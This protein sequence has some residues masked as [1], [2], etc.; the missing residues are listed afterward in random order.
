MGQEE[1]PKCPVDH[2]TREAW[3][4]K[5]S[6]SIPADHH[7]IDSVS[8]TNTTE[9]QPKCPVDHSARSVW[10]NKVSVSVPDAIEIDAS[11]PGASNEG[12]SS[13]TLSSV[14]ADSAIASNVDLP[15]ER[16]TS[17]IP[18]TA[19]GS[20]WV[21]PSQKQFYDAMKRKKWNPE[22]KD[23]ETI[24]PIHNAV[25]ERAWIHIL[26]WERSNYDEAVKMCG[27]IT[28]TS[29]K[30]DSKKLTPRAWINSTFLGYQKPFDRH[31]W[32]IDRCGK[33]IEYVIDFYGGAGK[34]ASFYLDVRPKLN[35]WEGVKLRLTRA[36]GWS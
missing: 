11:K 24:V 23:M 22:A 8:K 20:N 21:Y 6:G 15:I 35:T 32:K 5:T 29:F 19:A 36:V 18:R 1:Q 9:D 27:G 34:G 4:Q 31:D 26:N 10:A 25:N 13:D 28:L 30:G 12:C 16:A 7:K 33:E 2:T 17:S 14:A 3:L